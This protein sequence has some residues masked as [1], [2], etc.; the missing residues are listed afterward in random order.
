[1]L[2]PEALRAALLELAEFGFVHLNS[3]CDAVQVREAAPV[4]CEIILT[5]KSH[6]YWLVQEVKKEAKNRD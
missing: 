4:E 5:G 1:M 2:T 3:Y 6:K